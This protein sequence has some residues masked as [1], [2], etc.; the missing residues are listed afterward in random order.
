[1][2]PEG[3]SGWIGNPRDKVTIRRNT[4][5]TAGHRFSAL[6]D[7]AAKYRQKQTTVECSLQ[8]G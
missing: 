6:W 8:V 4:N 2:K 7:Y 1:V 5:N 3:S